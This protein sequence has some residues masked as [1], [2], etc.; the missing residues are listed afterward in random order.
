MFRRIFKRVGIVLAALIALAVAGGVITGCALDAPG[1]QGPRSDHFDGTH[2]FTPDAPKRSIGTAKFFEWQLDRHQGPW[3][4]HDDAQPGP[5]PPERVDGGGMRVTFIN[6]ATTL[7]QLDGVNILTDPIWAERA[8]P[9]SFAGPKR[10]RP[11]GLR[12]KDLPAIDA[13]VISHNHYDHLD[14]HALKALQD[15]FP[16]VQI[17]CGLGNAA[18]LESKGLHHVQQLDWWQSR[19]LGGITVVSVPNRHF[20]NRGLFDQDETLWSAWVFEGASGRAYFAG[21]T[22]YGD[23]FKLARQRLGPMRLAVLPIGAYKPEWFMGSV[24]MGPPEA[25]KAA[26]DLRARLSVPMHWGTFPLADDGEDEA[27]A[28]LKKALEGTQDPPQFQVLD[29]GEGAD[30]PRP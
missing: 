29:F 17:F 8:S 7:I 24:H 16:K 2:F 6:H 15:Q 25:V 1:Y 9:F 18:Y 28:D 19:P 5:P 3:P 4:T 27:V 13:I 30:V 10:V 21:D 22:A 12:M 14:I 11:P 23:H 26:Q 20:S